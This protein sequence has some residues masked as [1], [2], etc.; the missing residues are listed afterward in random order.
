MR[1]YLYAFILLICGVLPCFSQGES[2]IRWQVTVKMTS[3]D[4]GVA[5]FKAR[6]SDGWHLY[7][8]KL[9]EGGPKSTVI[10]MSQSTGISFTGELKPDRAPIKVHDTMFDLDLTWWD[11]DIAFRRPFKVTDAAKARLAGKITYMG[12][13]DETC[14]PPKTQ[15]FDKKI[16]K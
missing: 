12:C 14:S 1:R 6:I 3:A 5:T 10:D 13:N 4:S 2:P 15:A 11:S 7:G 8:F 16:G 9:P